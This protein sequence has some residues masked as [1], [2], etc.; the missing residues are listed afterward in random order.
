M[1]SRIHKARLKD[2]FLIGKCHYL[3]YSEIPPNNMWV[4]F[5]LQ[6]CATLFHPFTSHTWLLL[7]FPQGC[8]DSIERE[9]PI[10][11]SFIWCY[12]LLFSASFSKNLDSRCDQGNKARPTTQTLYIKMHT[13]CWQRRSGDQ[14][15]KV[16]KTKNLKEVS[17]LLR[18]MSPLVR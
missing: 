1:S 5:H 10:L 17:N 6:A 15:S 3:L 16:A 4:R 2:K 12:H 8:L 13:M 9:N 18:N 11:S 7:E 14:R